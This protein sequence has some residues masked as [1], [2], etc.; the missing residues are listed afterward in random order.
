MPADSKWLPVLTR[1]SSSPQE[2][3]AATTFG[4]FATQLVEA[5][6]QVSA[7]DPLAVRRTPSLFLSSYSLL[8]RCRCTC[9][10]AEVVV[11]RAPPTTLHNL[12]PPPS[13][14]LPAPRLRLGLHF[15]SAPPSGC[16]PQLRLSPSASASPFEKAVHSFASNV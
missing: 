6:D 16:A 4:C 15:L 3:V 14:A 5:A 11:R 2:C 12:Q 10:D 8:Q 9:C 1:T 13:V 7:L